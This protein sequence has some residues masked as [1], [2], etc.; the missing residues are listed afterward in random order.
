MDNFLREIDG[1]TVVTA[2]Q[3]LSE[4]VSACKPVVI[5]NAVTQWPVVNAAMTSPHALQDYLLKYDVGRE[6]EVFFGRP[7]INGNY[8]Y[9]SDMTGFNFEKRLMRFSDAL[10]ILTT[11]IGQSD[12]PSVYVGSIPSNAYLPGFAEQNQLS[13]IKSSV[14]PRIWLGHASVVSTHFD[15][16]DNIACVIAGKRRFTLFQPEAISS[17]YVGPIDNTM[18]GQPVSLAASSPF[19]PEKYPL[20][21]NVRE[22]AI[23]AELDTGDA[24]YLPKLWWHKVESLSSFNGLVNYW[25]DATAY[26]P[27]APY[28]SLLLSMITIAERPLNERLAWKQFFDHYVFRSDGHP[29]RHLPAEQHGIL[30]PL[31]NNYGKIR[32]LVMQLLRGA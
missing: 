1:R 8:Y 31:K 11:T 30:G 10:N 23:V 13:F 15:V 4:V 28:T 2:E 5:R 29:L 32:A 25:W 17:L 3:F 12:K 16:Y 26:G 21:E 24:L 20:F 18:A 9:S 14:V 19:S 27:D 7:E 6:T 22:K